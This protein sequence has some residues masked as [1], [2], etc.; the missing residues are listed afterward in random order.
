MNEH[1]QNSWDSFLKEVHTL[2][3]SQRDF[4]LW[5]EPLRPVDLKGDMLRI[6]VPSKEYCHKIEDVYLDIVKESLEKV[7]GKGIKLEYEAP[8]ASVQR[9][10]RDQNSM[11][12]QPVV[13]NHNLAVGFVTHLDNR[14]RM[15]NFYQSICNRLVCAAAESI[16]AKPGDNAFNPLFVYGASGVGKTHILHAVGNELIKRQPNLR[17]VYV[18]AQTFKQQYVEATIKRQDKDLFF[19]YYQNIDV[20]LID[21]IQEFSEARS[22]QNAFFQIFNNMK[23]LGKQIIITSDRA[24]VDLNG[25]EDRLF[26]R[27]K[28]GLTVEI[29][30]PDVQL[31]K[32]ILMAKVQEAGASL[33]EDVFRFIVKHAKN[34]VRDIEGALTSLLAHALYNNVPLNLALAERVLAQTVGIDEVKI[35]TPSIINTVC[36]YYNIE[37]KDLIGKKRKR[38]IVQAR[39]IVMLLAKEYSESSLA[40]IGAD[41]GG[42][43][44][45]TVIHGINRIQD[46]I[47]TN[48]RVA[49]EVEEIKELLNL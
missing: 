6:R 48:T 31:R 16:I 4:N 28:W 23:L 32:Q 19:N 34:N 24:P 22:T 14:M 8:R 25:L 37:A 42:R 45:S 27:L 26:T 10:R 11:A 41:L 12:S 3:H 17:A 20:L 35:N 39:H 2:L 49:N 33:P 15:D 18:P 47:A 5:F 44:H 1:L 43:D 38:E 9:P 46:D 40:A 13:Q 29:E 36:D 21:D 30:R 7:F